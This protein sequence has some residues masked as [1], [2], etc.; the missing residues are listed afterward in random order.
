MKNQTTKLND[1]ER[2]GTPFQLWKTDDL[3][4]KVKKAVKLSKDKKIKS[5]GWGWFARLIEFALDAYIE[6]MESEQ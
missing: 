4:D 1:P 3:I 5:M 6:K 2:R